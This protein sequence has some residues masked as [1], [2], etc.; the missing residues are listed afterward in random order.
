MYHDQPTAAAASN[1]YLISNQG[2]VGQQK[3]S[4]KEALTYPHS[5]LLKVHSS[6]LTSC[7]SLWDSM[8]EA[9]QLP[10][11][12][13][14]CRKPSYLC[15]S[16]RFFFV[17]LSLPSIVSLQVLTLMVSTCVTWVCCWLG[18]SAVSLSNW[19]LIR[20]QASQSCLRRLNKNSLPQELSHSALLSLLSDCIIYQTFLQVWQG[21]GL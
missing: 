14:L 21:W 16:F 3:T 5:G 9:E 4:M 18:S 1:Q 11:Q 2:C 6:I 12:V 17:F 20:C 13:G 19:M 7:S 15:V 8:H 10:V